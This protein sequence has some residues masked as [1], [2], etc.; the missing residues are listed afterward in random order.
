M[1]R[2]STGC[3]DWDTFP[4]HEKIPA[5]CHLGP[6]A[7]DI[8]AQMAEPKYSSVDDYIESQ[9]EQ[10]RASLQRVRT[11]IQRAVPEVEE[12]ITYN[13]PTYKLRGERLLYFAGWKEH[14]SLYPASSL[15]IAAFQTDVAPYKINKSTLQFPLSK[16]VPVELIERIARFRTTETGGGIKPKRVATR[17]S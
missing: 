5:W 3:L 12:S 2:L 17:K 14:Y 4:G 9:P 16:P 1:R 15:L 11:A 13:M 7:A 10:A 8:G 6:I